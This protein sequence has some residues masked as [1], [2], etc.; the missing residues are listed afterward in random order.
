M[1]DLLRL[2]PHIAQRTVRGSVGNAAR[3]AARLSRSNSERAILRQIRDGDQRERGALVRMS[4][5]ESIQL[6]RSRSVG[7]F[8]HIGRGHIP[9]VVPVNYLATH[10]GSVLFRSGPGPKLSS[11]LATE[12]VAFQVDDIDEQRRTGWSVLVTGRARRVPSREH[13]GFDEVPQL[14]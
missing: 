11:S 8:A 13:D 5:Q 6:L 4:R 12:L 3:A 2:I 7:R 10:D 14:H 1:H 9:S